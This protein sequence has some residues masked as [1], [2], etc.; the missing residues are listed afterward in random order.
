MTMPELKHFS[1]FPNESIAY[2][3][4]LPAVEDIWM[5]N[6][7]RS[8][9]FGPEC[10]KIYS[11]GVDEVIVLEDI[12]IDNAYQVFDRYQGLNLEQSKMALKL[13]A[14]YHA[15]SATHLQLVI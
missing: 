8:I 4:I 1:V 13:L 3:T 7:K 9:K 12:S 14:E 2:N 5:K 6:A 11:E 10:Y 15:A